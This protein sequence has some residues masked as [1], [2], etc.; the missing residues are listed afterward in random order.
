MLR[1]TT[2]FALYAI[3][4]LL[5]SFAAFS[6]L[7][8]S[9][10]DERSYLYE[11]LGTNFFRGHGLVYN[12][13]ESAL[14]TLSP[15]AGVITALPIQLHI[16]L[17]TL[18]II[19]V[20]YLL[21]K[22]LC[23]MDFT[24]EQTEIALLLISASL[25]FWLTITSSNLIGFLGILIGLILIENKRTTVAGFV[26]G[27]S[28]LTQI[29]LMIPA[30]L[31][32]LFYTY[33]IK[34][35]HYA[36]GLL[37]PVGICAVYVVFAYDI[38]LLNADADTPTFG[39]LLWVGGFVIAAA[40][41][42]FH[43]RNRLLR[44]VVLWGIQH[45]LWTWIFTEHLPPADSPIFAIVIAIATVTLFSRVR[46]QPQYFAGFAVSIGFLTLIPLTLSLP[47]THF[48]DSFLSDDFA[49]PDGQAVIH[50]GT[51]AL[52]IHYDGQLY[53]LITGRSA[54]SDDFV[55]REDWRSLF[56]RVA[57]A[58]ALLQD[59]SE[60]VDTVISSAFNYD[61]IQHGST[62]TL[63]QRQ[64]TIG[65]W[66]NTQ[67]IAIRYRPDVHLTAYE[68]DQTRLIDSEILRVGLHWRLDNVPE[69]GAAVN[70]SLVDLMGN[71]AATSR[72]EYTEKQWAVS[73][74]STYHALEITD[75]LLPGVYQL[76][77]TLEYQAGLLGTH[78]VTHV[79]KPFPPFEDGDELTQLAGLNLVDASFSSSA[80]L[81]LHWQVTAELEDDYLVFAHFVDL[82]TGEIIVQ[83]DGAPVD[84]RYP[85]SFWEAGDSIVDTRQFDLNGVPAGTY[86]I[87][88]GFYLPDGTRLSDEQDD[89]INLGTV[90]IDDN[91]TFNL[92]PRRQ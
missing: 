6:L 88:I 24:S 47:S 22:L 71:L 27:L 34:L 57:P 14:L 81:T 55:R 41:L 33:D 8:G 4:G 37:F 70:L 49:L 72:T 56:N 77:A 3:A 35:R 63:Y 46:L 13:G 42:S 65:S 90:I 30:L 45:I 84:G 53:R 61:V 9:H 28:I 66:Q 40:I 54:V 82:D 78:T 87:N 79:V 32:P 11:R 26:A 25:P 38:M 21:H 50:D 17:Q 67:S 44:L 69:A 7:T 92:L 48:S 20:L 23:R 73:V 15:L 74:P 80:T 85:T 89:F 75:E 36:G 58:Y 2:T 68:L 5:I 29:E 59:D 52:L 86:Q 1:R 51:D 10:L 76:N 39:E 91:I 31:I 18:S 60:L 83:A 64:T 19:G 43:R 62:Y 16:L 12:P